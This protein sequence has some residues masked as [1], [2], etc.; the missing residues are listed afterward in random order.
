MSTKRKAPR[1][2][3]PSQID[4]ISKHVQAQRE[5]LFKAMGILEACR[6]AS[7]SMLEADCCCEEADV[8]AALSAAYDILNNVARDLEGIIGE[9]G[10]HPRLLPSPASI[11]PVP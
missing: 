7:D 6:L 4:S 5:A 1:D 8:G 10:N 11:K 2:T 9:R 3:R